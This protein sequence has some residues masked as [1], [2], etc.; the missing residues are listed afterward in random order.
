MPTLC[1]PFVT[2]LLPPLPGSKGQ[3]DGDESESMHEEQGYS[4]EG[5]GQQEVGVT[6]NKTLKMEVDIDN[7]GRDMEVRNY[8]WLVDHFRTLWC[9]NQICAVHVLCKLSSSKNLFQTG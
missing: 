6:S 4:S 8:D 9:G 1:L 3:V 7:E 5:E 2:S